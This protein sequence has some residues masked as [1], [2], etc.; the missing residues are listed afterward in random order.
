LVEE[1]DIGEPDVDASGAGEDREG[2]VGE[3]I[4]GRRT[5][6]TRKK[7]V[8]C[9]ERTLRRKASRDGVVH[10]GNPLTREKGRVVI[11]K[12]RCTLDRPVTLNKSMTEYQKDA[13]RGSVLAPIKVLLLV[14]GV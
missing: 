12:G 6:S 7:V 4:S 3:G 5:R 11:V 2:Y 13:V 9:E 8:C 10:G 14:N 1:S